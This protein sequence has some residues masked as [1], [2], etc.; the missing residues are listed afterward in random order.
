MFEQGCKLGQRFA[1]EKIQATK[2]N[3]SVTG[4]RDDE[5]RSPKSEIR[6]KGLRE[7]S[8][9]FIGEFSCRII[10]GRIDPEIAYEP[11]EILLSMAEIMIKS[12]ALE[13]HCGI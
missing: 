10:F 12:M 3:G 11:G 6:N 4:G 9:D 7:N 13:T 2:R 8:G 1:V 5:I